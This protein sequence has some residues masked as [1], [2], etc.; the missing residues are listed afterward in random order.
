MSRDNFSRRVLSILLSLILIVG[1]MPS[2]ALATDP[3]SSTQEGVD[4]TI[5]GSHSDE[6]NQGSDIVDNENQSQEST[7]SDSLDTSSAESQE[8]V[9]VALSDEDQDTAEAVIN[10]NSMAHIQNKGDTK[11]TFSTDSAGNKTYTLGTTGQSLRLEALYLSVDTEL[12]GSI[13]YKT[14]IQNVGWESSFV[15]DG[16]RS[17]TQGKSL[18]LEAVQ[19][20]L[21]DELADQYDIYYRAHVQNFGWLAW[22]SNGRCAG[23]EGYSYRVE[24]IQICLVK[25]DESGNSIAPVSKEQNK[26]AAFYKES[27]NG[28]GLVNYSTHVQNIGWQEYE[29]DGDIAGTTGKGLRAEAIKINLGE[30]IKSKYPDSGITYSVHVQNI[31]DQEAVSNNKVAGTSGKSYRVEALRVKL[32]GSI[33]NDYDVYY[34][35]HVANIG[36]L[37]WAKNYDWAGTSSAA[38]RIEALQIKLVKKGEAAPG[39]TTAS[40]LNTS[41]VFISA[42]GQVNNADW[43]ENGTTGQSKSLTGIKAS[44]SENQLNIS[45]N[46]SYRGHFSNI[47]WTSYSSSGTEVIG[48]GNMLEAL[49]MKLTGTLANYYD[50][51]YRVYIANVGWIG[52]AKN[53]EIAGSVGFSLPIESYQVKVVPKGGTA[54]GSTSN[55]QLTDAVKYIMMN[56]ASNQTSSSNWLILVDRAN[57]K[58]GVFYGSKGNWKLTYYWDNCNG[59]EGHR[60]PAGRF[61]VGSR[62][63]RF[64]ENHGYTC[65]YWTQIYNSILFHSQLYYPGT[66]QIL[67]GRM[68]VRCS[69][70]CIRLYYQNAKWINE[71]IPTGTTVYIY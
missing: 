71:N 62:G 10:S 67:D 56:K 25:K 48:S 39:K 17:G 49:S 53:G 11:G 15:K 55:H 52:W 6:N 9:L 40:Y 4:I 50:V 57:C 14:H 43:V 66:T 54:P 44:I 16:E 33:A 22:T 31:G 13:E 26:S 35:V 59:R 51:Y 18:R 64:G 12:S 65:W 70:G 28:N 8:E 27:S 42:L 34:R 69:E 19:I 23:S 46:V 60:T 7:D 37:D 58:T 68:G 32:T 5:E 1:C 63:L 30:E 2:V 47:G 36:W 38:L 41:Q 45:G 29:S 24:S 61:T 3:E 20:R 21:T